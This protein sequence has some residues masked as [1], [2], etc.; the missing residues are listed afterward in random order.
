M[1]SFR[2]V[3]RRLGRSTAFTFVCILTLGIGI[4]AN[5]AIFSVLN[6]V[7][8]KPL[9]YP[10]PERLMAVWQTA[11]GI[12]LTD[13]NASPSTYFT[14]RDESRTFEDIGLWRSESVSITGM[15]EPERVRALVV[16][17]GTLPILGVPPALG[18]WFTKTDDSP[19]GAQTVMLMDS[20]WRRRFGGDRSVIGQRLMVDGSPREIIGIMPERFRFMDVRPDVVLPFRLNRSEAFIGNFSYQAIA[21]LKP[22]ATVTQANQDVARMLPIMLQ[23]FRPAPGMNNQM[24]VE[25]R[26]GPNV[27]PLK[28]DVVG[29]VGTVLWV[30]MGT[31]GIVLLIACANVA[32]LLLVRADGRQQ[33]FA[34]RSALGASWSQIAREMLSESLILGLLGGAAGLLLSYGAIRLLVAIGPSSL[35]RLDEISMDGS[36]LAFTLV[37]SVFAG[38]LFG[39]IPVL[40]Y[41][42]PRIAV[43]LRSGGRTMSEG[44]ERHR[45]RGA[46]VIIQVALALVLLISSGLMIRS[47]SALKR[48]QPGFTQPDQILTLRISIPSTQ[49]PKPEAVARMFQDMVEKVRAVPGVTSV[50]LTNSITMDGSNNNDPIFAEDHTYAESTI[51]PIRRY[52][53]ISPGIFQTLG[54]PLI[55][56]RDLSWTDIYQTRNVVLVSE[57]LARELWGSAAAA[58]GKRVREN[59]KGVWRE[60][61][62]VVRNEYD[63]GVHQKAPTIVYWPMMVRDL[64]DPGV[65]TQRTLAFAIR[66][67]RTGTSGF[68]PEVQRAIWSVNPNVPVAAVRTVRQI[69]DASMARTSFTLVML[70]IAAATA[71][72]LGVIG[73]YGVISY[74]ISQRTREIGIRM[75]LG[76][77][78]SSVQRLFVR[79][80]LTLTAL[81]IACGVV[82]A[83]PLT[84]LM[85]S[86]LYGTSPLDAITYLSVAGVLACAALL[87]AYVPARRATVIEPLTA[88]R[89]E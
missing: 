51:P 46:L 89:F 88:L 55:A 25:A 19:G 32:N 31:V 42:G 6:G 81:G 23:K 47:L 36:V 24:L 30:L 54:N 76:A 38:C 69:S 85:T 67:S 49:V 40:K 64:W 79:Q 7:L 15:A 2:Q 8:L 71:L 83:V 27:R 21:R 86:L 53:R 77:S 12:N 84:R 37:V 1:R 14:Y 65:E 70:S 60:V 5:T 68:L 29:D 11:P 3:L 52:K 16:T 43:A 10:E 13:L 35:P 26:L 63:D 41:A 82:A 56:G 33:E 80:G 66:S 18:R 22:G 4:G 20:Y 45:A 59:P 87:A 9:P 44:R 78:G 34:I 75:A 39:V 50:A 48:V 73:I 57:N 58:I 74:S 17:D 61:I 72:L 62:G 28:R